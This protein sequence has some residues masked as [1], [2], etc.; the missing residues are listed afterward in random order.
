MCAGIINIYKYT[1]IFIFLPQGVGGGWERLTARP[2]TGRIWIPLSR[3]NIPNTALLYLLYLNDPSSKIFFVNIK[4]CV[5]LFEVFWCLTFK[6]SCFASQVQTL[7]YVPQYRV[8]MYQYG[9]VPGKNVS[10]WYSTY[11]SKN[12]ILWV[13]RP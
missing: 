12:K 9:T 3:S 5:F 13:L 1:Y 11:M 6:F 4:I 7:E 2:P 10:V 8:R